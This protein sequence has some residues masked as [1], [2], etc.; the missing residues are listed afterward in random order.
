MSLVGDEYLRTFRMRMFHWRQ[1][2]GRALDTLSA[3]DDIDMNRI[4][5]LGQSFGSSI[6][7][8]LL[9]L[10]DRLK[11]AVLVDP[12]FTFRAVPPEADAINYVA[13]VK[14]PVLML[15]GRHDYVFPLE[16]SQVPLFE[17]WGTPPA[18][19]RHVVFEAG[20]ADHP[21]SETIREVLAWLDRYLGPVRS[22]AQ[23]R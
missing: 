3:R 21:R 19:K 2:L 4:G 12:G 11:A 8:P 18:H 1:D 5:Y 20:H 15:N 16:T 23:Q 14:M 9:A 10:E 22:S 13:H 6:P 17:R 7:L